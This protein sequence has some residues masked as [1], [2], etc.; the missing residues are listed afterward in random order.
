MFQGVGPCVIGGAGRDRDAFQLGATIAGD[1]HLDPVTSA[2]G[3][4]R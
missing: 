3:M 1:R 4:K 2:C